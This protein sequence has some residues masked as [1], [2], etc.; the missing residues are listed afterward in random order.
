MGAGQDILDHHDRAGSNCITPQCV[1]ARVGSARCYYQR[2][3]TNQ[4]SPGS[5]DNLGLR[6]RVRDSRACAPNTLYFETLFLQSRI[7]LSKQRQFG[8]RA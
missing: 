5:G 6:S 4:L 2:D 3:K 1:L 7:V 8:G